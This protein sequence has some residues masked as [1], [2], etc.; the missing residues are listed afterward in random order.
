M[1]ELICIVCPKGCHLQ[2]DETNGYAV[3]GNACEKGMEYGVKELR[4]PTR[5]VTSTVRIEG[6]EI[7][8]APVKTDRDIP[9]SAIFDAVRLLDD[10]VLHAPVELG[11]IVVENLLGT[12]ANF[13]TTRSLP[14]AK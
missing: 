13:V 6:A 10:I 4:N 5:V 9:K 7:P 8:R 12:G 1:K 3:T 11:H 2:V 14:K